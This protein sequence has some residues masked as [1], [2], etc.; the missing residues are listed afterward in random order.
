M[1]G[2]GQLIAQVHVSLDGFCDITMLTY[3]TI[4]LEVSHVKVCMLQW[5]FTTYT[6]HT[7]GAAFRLTPPHNSTIHRVTC[8][9]LSR[10]WKLRVGGRQ[11]TSLATPHTLK[12]GPPSPLG[13]SHLGLAFL[14]GRNDCITTYRGKNRDMICQSYRRQKMVDHH[15][16]GYTL[17]TQIKSNIVNFW[18]KIN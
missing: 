18:P 13:D 8:Y 15:L 10:I 17:E 2:E 11:N 5:I 3:V 12:Y 1:E 4:S 7:G 9:K 6:L 14:L 16:V